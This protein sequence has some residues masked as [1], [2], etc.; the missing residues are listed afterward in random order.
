MARPVK[1][2]FLILYPVQ[3]R[4]GNILQT[5]RPNSFP[6][7]MYVG[8]GYSQTVE[9]GAAWSV[10]FCGSNRCLAFENFLVL[11]QAG[12]HLGPFT[13]GYAQ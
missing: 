10:V 9:R 11:F 8:I 4:I 7:I 1:E 13:V 2:D 6:G 3:D 12:Q 5:S